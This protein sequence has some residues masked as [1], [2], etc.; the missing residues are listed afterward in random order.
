MALRILVVD[1]DPASLSPLSSLLER[2]GFVVKALSDSTRALEV[3]SEFQPH[4]VVL[5]Y[6]MPGMHGGD[7]AWQLA[8]DPAFRDVRMVMTSAYS[9]EEIRRRLPPSR[10]PILPKPVDFNAL[11]AVIQGEG[12]LTAAGT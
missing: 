10:I 2:K 12:G 7:V 1:D 3:A 4:V 11:L 9:I 8:S 5:D 6:L